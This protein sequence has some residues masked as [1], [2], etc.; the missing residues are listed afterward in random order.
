MLEIAACQCPCH[1]HNQHWVECETCERTF[2]SQRACQQ[3]M[4]AL[5]HNNLYECDTC[6]SV[7]A[8]QDAVNQHMQAKGHWLHYCQ[9]CRRR[10]ESEQNYRAHMNSATHRD[11]D[12]DCRY[13]DAEFVTSSGALHHLELGSCPAAPD[14]HRARL[15]RGFQKLDINGWVTNGMWNGSQW[16]CRICGSMFDTSE[17]VASHLLSWVHGA[18]VYHCLDDR[19]F[20]DQRFVSLA[21]VFNH[22]ES[23]SCGFI[24]FEDVPAWMNMLLRF[25]EMKLE[26]SKPN[27][28]EYSD[29]LY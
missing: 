1:A 28:R 8:S 15:Y 26:L 24:C 20:C 16:Q 25:V 5:G 21:A 23:E 4:K 14:T 19:G 17:A 29:P 13:C 10:F 18:E 6:D 22:L 7:F 9:I 27:L 3:H 11:K 12:V 2:V